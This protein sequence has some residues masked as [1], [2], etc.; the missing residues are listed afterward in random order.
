MEFK[1]EFVLPTTPEVAYK[2][3]VDPNFIVK[4]LKDAE[5]TSIVDEDNFSTTVKAGIGFIKG[6][7]AFKFAYK[8]KEA[9]SYAKIVGNGSGVGSK[10]GLSIEFHMS[11]SSDSTTVNWKADANFSGRIAAVAG[12]ILPSVIKKNTNEFILSFT[13]GMKKELGGN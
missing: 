13:D 6:K 11:E 3:L 4:Y 5:N 8:E 7:V 2:Y 1:G 9:P 10:I 12:S